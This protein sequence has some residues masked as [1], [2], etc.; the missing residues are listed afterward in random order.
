MSIWQ[1][2]TWD[3][4]RAAG[5]TAFALLTLAV[6]LGLALSLKL[7][8]NRWPRII[9]AELHNFLTLLALLFTG[10]HVIAV[11]A[12]PYTHFGLGEVLVPLVSHYRPVWMALGIVGLYLGLVVGLS[13]WLRP[14][15]G[16]AWWRR[17]HTATLALYALV[18]VH[19]IATGSD[20]GTW[21]GVV[22][23]L[24]S[25]GVV[26]PLLA[27]RLWPR[28]N[29]AGYARPSGADARRA[30]VP[31]ARREMVPG[32]AGTVEARRDGLSSGAR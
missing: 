8:S 10:V 16:Y 9:N 26:G 2:V 4:A 15:I 14:K 28:A 17:F 27:M 3:V 22:I 18:V 25:I 5:F 7:Q 6:A 21:F 20:S 12:D 24:T 11:W 1:A 19:G 29:R 13:T 31:V 30:V 32:L 23:Y